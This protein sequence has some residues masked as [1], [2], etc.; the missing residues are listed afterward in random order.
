MPSGMTSERVER[1]WPNLTNVGPRSSSVRL[2]L[3]PK[4]GA[5][6]SSTPRFSRLP[7]RT[8]KTNRTLAGRAPAR[9]GRTARGSPA[10]YRGQPG[11]ATRGLYHRPWPSRYPGK[12]PI[13]LS[14]RLHARRGIGLVPGGR[15]VTSTSPTG[16]GGGASTGGVRGS[17]GA[18]GT[19]AVG[20]S[21][22]RRTRCSSCSI[23]NR[24]SS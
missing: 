20:R 14:A 18:S 12:L 16:G 23:L 5:R 10:G 15:G 17:V 24:R 11:A 1:S 2:S 22:S 9:S 7:R 13:G 8:S 6:S 21:S 19:A 4:F 3:T